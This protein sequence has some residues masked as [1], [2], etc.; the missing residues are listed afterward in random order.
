[1]VPTVRHCGAIAVKANIVK[2]F[3][4]RSDVLRIAFVAAMASSLCPFI[5]LCVW[6]IWLVC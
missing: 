6:V 4:I 2:I 1:M 3:S 5:H